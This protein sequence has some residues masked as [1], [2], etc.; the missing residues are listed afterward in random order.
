MQ[1]KEPKIRHAETLAADEASGTVPTYSRPK[2]EHLRR[3]WILGRQWT[4]I[5]A[6][7]V[8]HRSAWI[9]QALSRGTSPKSLPRFA[10]FHCFSLPEASTERAHKGISVG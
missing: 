8:P 10:F 5:S 3:L 7:A 2:I 9:E 6:F 4:C 1:P